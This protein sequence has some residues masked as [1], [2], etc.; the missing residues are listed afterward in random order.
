MQI[1]FAGRWG[2]IAGSALAVWAC[3]AAHAGPVVGGSSYKLWLGASG[4]P[5]VG[6][7]TLGVFSL[8]FDGM[9]QVFSISGAAG[10]PRPL[11]VSV[12]ELQLDLGGGRSQIEIDLGFDQDPFSTFGAAVG[13]GQALGDGTDDTLDLAS[14]Q[15]LLSA[16]TTWFGSDGST[17]D[18]D[19]TRFLGNGQPLPWDGYLFAPNVVASAFRQTGDAVGI[20]ITLVAQNVVSSP[21]TLPL[22][23]LALAA[24]A[25]RRR[26]AAGLAN[27]AAAA[28]RS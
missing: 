14:P 19:L 2:R 12:N 13:L 17:R 24:V 15:H 7:Q 22:V 20:R 4:V 3:A 26:A 5:G 9:A 6:I 27:A 11:Q 8:T 28:R 25:L 21:G 10:S 16:K 1:A 18:T 23:A